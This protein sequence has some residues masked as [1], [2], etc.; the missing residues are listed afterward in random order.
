M[1][2]LQLYAHAC[3]CGYSVTLFCQS[4]KQIHLYINDKSNVTH[5]YNRNVLSAQE[6]RREGSRA[7]RLIHD[8]HDIEVIGTL[9]ATTIL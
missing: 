6:R 5:L 8:R 9:L 1:T 3:L 7:S 4:N 2:I